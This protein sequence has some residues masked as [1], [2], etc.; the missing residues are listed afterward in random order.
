MSRTSVASGV[1]V[2]TGVWQEID[3]SLKKGML[4]SSCSGAY[5]MEELYGGAAWRIVGRGEFRVGEGGARVTGVRDG[6][7]VTIA[8]QDISPKI[9]CKHPDADIYNDWLGRCLINKSPRSN[10]GQNSG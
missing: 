7:R 2:W 3:A 1:S 10:S 5:C 8:A 9:I 4:S 6:A